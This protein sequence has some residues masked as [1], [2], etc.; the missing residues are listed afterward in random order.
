M[1]DL[2]FKFGAMDCGKSTALLQAVHNCESRNTRV[3]LLKP[4]KDTKEGDK[5]VS[6]LGISRK[7]DHLV[8]PSEDLYSWLCGNIIGL[9]H[10]FVDEAQFLTP[11][12]VDDLLIFATFADIPVTC[13]GLRNDFKTRFFPGSQR[14]MEVSTKLEGLSN[15]CACG[16]TATINTRV[17]ADGEPIF[18]GEQVAID[19][20]NVG[21]ISLCPKCYMEAKMRSLGKS[22]KEFKKIRDIFT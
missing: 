9:G 3:L 5:V 22:G 8:S 15:E 13:Y 4:E 18:E 20:E 1:A 12:N 14:L 17:N 21:Y 7:V 10:V 19:G 2:T 11:E 6:R 16:R